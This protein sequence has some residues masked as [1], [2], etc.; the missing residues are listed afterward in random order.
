MSDTVPVSAMLDLPFAR[1]LLGQARAIDGTLNLVRDGVSA[2]AATEDD[3]VAAE[4]IEEARLLIG[5]LA[6]VLDRFVQPLIGSRVRFTKRPRPILERDPEGTVTE[7]V[8][9]DITG[10]PLARVLLDPAHTWAF[11]DD[12][13][14][15][16]DPATVPESGRTCPA[17]GIETDPKA[18]GERLFRCDLPEGHTP[19]RHRSAE[20]RE[21]DR[22]PG[23]GS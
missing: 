13:R 12:L 23:D 18:T 6:D 15:T 22:V 17:V 3:R 7:I 4:M 20:G 21:W 14:M 11:V 10:R 16:A 5:E 1:T 8:T 2:D 19:T 9:D